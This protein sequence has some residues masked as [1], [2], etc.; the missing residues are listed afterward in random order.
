MNKLSSA[1][2]IACISTQVSCGQAPLVKLETTVRDEAGDRIEG[3]NVVAGFRGVTP[4]KGM[5]AEAETDEDGFALLT[6]NAYRKASLRINKSGYYE[7]YERNIR[8]HEPHQ[9]PRTRQVEFTMREQINPI[10]LYAKRADN[11][12]SAYKLPAKDEWIGFDLEIGHWVEPH[13]KGERTDLM[14]RYS[15]EFLGLSISEKNLER[16][17][18]L[19]STGPLPWTEERE[20]HIYGDWSG[21]M[22]I[23]FP[24]ERDGILPI[25]M[26]DGYLPRSKLRMPHQ[27]GAEGYEGEITFESSMPKQ[28]TE[29]RKGYF[30]RLRVR[31]RNGQILEANY[32][33]INSEIEF[34]P[35]GSV[36]FTYYFNPEVNDRN[37]EFNPEQN[38]FK[39][40]PRDNRVELP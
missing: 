29:V 28:Q 20:R 19:N 1:L 18:E 3:V 38:L 14:F 2:A 34:D 36:E 24:N 7:S 17:R 40:L 5:R 25:T 23:A 13:G 6:G 4:D 37:L 15:N 21:T 9:L 33:K 27:A 39:D 11:N 32:A 10:T 31:E 16:A 30:L 26:K 8:V 22:E 12:G 35:R